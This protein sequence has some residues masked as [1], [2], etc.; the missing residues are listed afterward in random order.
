MSEDKIDE[1]VLIKEIQDSW[2]SENEIKQKLIT[3]DYIMMSAYKILETS[4]TDHEKVDLIQKLATEH[5]FTNVQEVMQFRH[6]HQS[7]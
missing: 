6:D 4:M 2:N 1:E 3:A 7:S 5:E